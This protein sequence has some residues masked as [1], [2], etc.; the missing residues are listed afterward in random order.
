ML[1]TLFG[2]FDE[3]TARAYRRQIWFAC[4]YALLEGVAFGLTLPALAA[5]LEDDPAKWNWFLALA[6]V[7]VATLCVRAAQTDTALRTTITA[8]NVLHRRIAGHLATLPVDR[9]SPAHSGELIRTVWPGAAEV[10]KNVLTNLAPLLR[11]VLTPAVILV[12]TA[13]VDWRPALVMLATAPLLWL[14]YRRTTVA[15]D[16]AEQRTHRAQSEATARIVEFAEEQPT[17]RAS[18]R[19]GLG[20][21][22]LH[23]ALD[24]REQ[25][26]RAGI[27]REL[28]A[29]AGFGTAIHLAVAALATVVAW[30]VSRGGQD[31]ALLVAL[32]VL[33]LRF[34]EPIGT[35][36]ELAR[37]MRQSAA[38]VR[39]TAEILATQPL[40]VPDEPLPVPA[41]E[42]G[43]GLSLRFAGVR[44]RY[45]DTESPAVD[46]IELD[47]PAGSATAIVGS[48][49]AGKTTLLRLAARFTDPDE[50]RVSLGGADL[51]E[52]APDELYGS[53]GV[54]LQDV[55]LL[56]GTIR[57]NILLGRPSA[58]EA[59]LAE[60]ARLSG[61]DEIVARL[62]LGWDSPVGSASIGLSGGERQRVCLARVAV[63]DAPVLLLDEATAALDPMNELLVHRWITAMSGRRTVLLVAHRLNTIRTADRIVVLDQGRILDQGGHAELLERCARYR[64]L[65]RS[66]E[67][68][69]G[70]RLRA[71][72]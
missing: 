61:V 47:L 32:L 2:L 34:T 24:E 70:W 38:A 17:L 21:R 43:G 48:S 39:R 50:G 31:A 51:R 3:A 64:K 57:D 37:G 5:V 11:G 8:I 41:P 10:T 33:V 62:P 54:V 28:L 71:P 60:A 30:L 35:V 9:F 72:V 65:W 56:D 68:A 6:L 1:R 66:H 7:V 46:G 14:V 22:L 45:P 19:L 15:L 52:L 18:G 16:R 44:F 53:L 42:A 58:S 13:L 12:I 36:A 25:A 40:S 27:G 59:E 69:G 26:M 55:V 63:Q 29:R 49:G 4:G 23:E 20:D 67:Q